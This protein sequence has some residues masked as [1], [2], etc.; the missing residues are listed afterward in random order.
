MKNYR[1]LVPL[2]MVLMLAASVYVLAND[3][4]SVQN[5]YN[6]YLETARDYRQQDI[7]IDAEENYLLAIEVNPNLDIYLELGSLYVEQ[8]LPQMSKKLSRNLLEMYPEDAGSYEY[9]LQLYHAKGD[10]IECYDLIDTMRKRNISSEYMEQLALEIEYM[11]YFTGEY[12]DVSVF[13]GGMCPVAREGVWGFVDM[14]GTRYVGLKYVEVGPFSGG[15][16]PVVE[17]NGD[18]YYIDNQ[19]NKKKVILNVENIVKLGLIENNVFALYNGENWGFYDG[20]GNH[21]FGAYQETSNIGNG[22]AAVNTG[23][24]WQLVGYNGEDL[25][26]Q[27]YEGVHMD[28]KLIVHRND[29]IFVQVGN[30][31]QMIDSSGKVYSKHTYEDVRLFNDTTYA[32]VKIDGLWG[33]VDKNGDIVIE[34][35]YEDARSFSNGFA[36]VKADG[37]WGY[38]NAEGQMVIVNEFMD[39]KDFTTRGTAFVMLEDE[40]E[41]LK[42]YKYNH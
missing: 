35:Q 22:V 25:A 36:A 5:E 13:G 34:P 17:E 8:G 30:G 9:A 15:L 31:Y 14:L 24:G 20:D 1:F 2:V 37:L 42:L 39:A 12:D 32:A 7:F 28:E 19:G 21:L 26:G 4:A 11:Y 27:T 38:I 6:T 3:K 40:W 33:F 23:S 41:L 16:A 10:Y 29:R 18:A